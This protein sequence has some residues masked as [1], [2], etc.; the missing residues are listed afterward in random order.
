MQ[1]KAFD[2]LQ[3]YYSWEWLNPQNRLIKCSDLHA[4]IWSTWF[5]MQFLINLFF[6]LSNFLQCGLTSLKYSL[7]SRITMSLQSAIRFLISHKTHYIINPCWFQCPS[8]C[9]IIN[10]RGF[11]CPSK[12]YIINPCG[13]QCPSKY[14][15]INP[16]WFQCPSKC[17]I[18]NPCGF[19]CPS[20]CY[21][22]N[23]CW[24]QCP[25]K[26]YIINPCGFQ[27]PSKCYII[28]PCWF[29]CPSK[30]ITVWHPTTTWTD[31]TLTPDS[32]P[33][34]SGTPPAGHTALIHR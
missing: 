7:F 33:R 19:Q 21:I 27:C 6:K 4:L 20:K 1:S 15:I 11:Q 24:F 32:G 31:D 9:Y 17:Y 3:G 34:S 8:K 12:C 10:P 25:S 26:C 23:P 16:C 13:F 29:Q 5:Q 28:N 14:Y 2:W 18:I 30:C 22:I